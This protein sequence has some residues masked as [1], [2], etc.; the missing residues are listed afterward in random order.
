M[1]LCKSVIN[2]P[3]L[4]ILDESM[5]ALDLNNKI[6]FY[7]IIKKLNNDG[8]TIIMVSNDINHISKHVNSIIYINK[9]VKLYNRHEFFC[10]KDNTH[11]EF[12]DIC[13]HSS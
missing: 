13:L 11:D 5:S 7:D 3:K 4:L 6:Y 8:V 9:S 1:Y 10:K 12:H 2:K